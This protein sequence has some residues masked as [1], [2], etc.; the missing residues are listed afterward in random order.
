MAKKATERVITINTQGAENSISAL[1]EQIKTLTAAQKDLDKESEEFA[2]ITAQLTAAQ[3][4]LR[5]AVQG[6]TAAVEGSYKS[7]SHQLQVLKEQRKWMQ[8]GT[9]EY[10]EATKRL[11]ELD[12]KLKEMDAE[13]GV[14]GRNVGNYGSAFDG[15]NG[16]VR[17][18]AKELPNLV[19]GANSLFGSLKEALPVLLENIAG[20]T[21]MAAAQRAQETATVGATAA[22]TRAIPVLTALGAVLKSLM[23]WQTVLVIII[24]L[25]A[26]FGDA[27]FGWLKGLFSAEKQ[28]TATAKAQ[29]EF[30]A[31]LKEGGSELGDEMFLLK[32]LTLEWQALGGNLAAQKKFILDNADAF[33]TLGVE[34]GSVLD[35]ERLL[36]Q[37]TPQF[38]EAMRLRAQASAAKELAEKYYSEAADKAIQRMAEEEKWNNMDN[39]FTPTQTWVDY[40]GRVHTTGGNL[41]TEALRTKTNID[42]LQKEEKQ[43]QATGDALFDLA[44]ARSLAADSILKNLNLNGGPGGGS[45]GGS[46]STSTTSSRYT[47]EMGAITYGGSMSAGGLDMDARGAIDASA[48]LEASK[49]RRDAL[50]EMEGKTAKER[51]KIE[52]ELNIELQ[53]IEEIRL[54]LHEVVL[55]ELLTSEELSVEERMALEQELTDVQIEQTELRQKAAEKAA[56][57]EKK[58]EEEVIKTKKKKMEIA[59]KMLQNTSS[60]LNSMSSLY[61]EN[62]KEYKGMAS[63]LVVIDTIT[64]AMAGW[65]QGMEYGGP[66]ALPMAIFNLTTSLAMGATQLYKLLSTNI[67]GSNASSGIQA[68]NVA[69]SM[70]AAYTRSL[71]G[72]NELTE[73]NKDMR[74]YVLEQDI[75]DA[76]KA[77]KARVESA[78]F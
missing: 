27:L 38:I 75:T 45:G 35:A 54:G 47:P 68:P 41:T 25:L 57:A 22:S 17:N 8:E 2:D 13:I 19:D 29:E 46:S 28:I 71:M 52:Q 61:E 50:I 36:V 55:N 11:S 1:R 39:I 43:A 23:T 59:T 3:V 60:I 44:A 42:N 9:K 70:P 26:K 77:S 7:Y 6:N 51:A 66:A 16:S 10:I 37:A 76:Q 40:D 32:Q 65:K 64:S 12:A 5:N 48:S 72:D 56:A 62:S 21:E 63:A 34:I 20:F 4:E 14:F 58:A 15:L 31:A 18:V 78:S 67:D 74:V 49:A 24:S 69:S 73:M 53:A 33:K 30:T